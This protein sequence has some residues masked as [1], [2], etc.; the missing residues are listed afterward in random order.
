MDRTYVIG[1]WKID[2]NPKRDMRHYIR[3]LH[4]TLRYL[5]GERIVMLSDDDTLT[6][7]VCD[8]VAAQGGQCHAMTR[9]V[10]DLEK[11][12]QSDAFLDAVRAYGTRRHEITYPTDREKG[13]NHFTRDYLRG[14]EASYRAMLT[15]WHSKF[16]LLAEI[17]GHNPFGTSELCWA[18]ASVSRF[19]GRRRLWDFKRVAC[20]GGRVALY[21]NKLTKR[22]AVIPH[23]ASVLLVPTEDAA[24]LGARY[25]AAFAD[26]LHEPYPNDEETIIHEMK[27][28]G[29]DVFAAIRPA[30]G[31]VCPAARYDGWQGRKERLTARLRKRT[32]LLQANPLARCAYFAPGG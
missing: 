21:P 23:N 28:R 30:C 22:G 3:S 19:V 27:M 24:A 11:Y 8:L 15:I 1:F 9:R 32:A 25:D 31:D 10:A 13:E 12:R 4:L 14:T 6:R 7:A 20:V 16:D 17:A 26:F 29:D 5:E 2:E 18:D